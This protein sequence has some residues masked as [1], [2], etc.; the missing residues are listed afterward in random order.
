MIT[1]T[2]KLFLF[3]TFLCNSVCYGSA[4]QIKDRFYIDDETFKIDT[5]GDEFYIHVGNNVWLVTHT[6]NRD[7]SGLFAYETNL[8]RF[9]GSNHQMEYENK[10]KCPYCYLYWPIGKACGNPE[11]PSKY[12]S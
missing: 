1:R 7:A 3:L 5:K 12:K 8:S 4:L 11:C 10:W 2:T 6:I 9:M